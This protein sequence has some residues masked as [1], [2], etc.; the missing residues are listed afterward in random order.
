MKKY[1]VNESEAFNLMSMYEH[2]MVER[3]AM[4]AGE[5]PWEDNI[6]ARINEIEALLEKGQY[7]GSLVDWPTLKR[8]REIKAER[9]A[10]R[11]NRCIRAGMSERDAGRAFEM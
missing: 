2:L 7:V 9:Q 5:K 11:Y 10:I 8:I 1:R 3:D 6:E 4:I